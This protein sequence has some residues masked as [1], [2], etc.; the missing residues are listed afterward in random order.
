MPVIPAL[1]RL[2]QE[3]FEF[4]ASLGYAARLYLRYKIKHFDYSSKVYYS[5]LDQ[6]W[7]YTVVIPT[8]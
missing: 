5:T 6:V 8:T 4:K 2:R 7:W 1:R 3:D